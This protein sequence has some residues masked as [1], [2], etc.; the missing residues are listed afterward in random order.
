MLLDGPEEG[1]GEGTVHPEEASVQTRTN[2]IP[3]RSVNAAAAYI[4]FITDSRNKVKGEMEAMVHQ[5]LDSLVRA[6]I[7]LGSQHSLT[8]V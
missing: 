6:Y 8:V 7:P 3:L 5:G 2:S 1:D 4:P